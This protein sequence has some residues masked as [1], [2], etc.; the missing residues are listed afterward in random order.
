MIRVLIADDHI[1]LVE[2]LQLMLHQ[3]KNIEVVGFAA[4]GSE[5][6]DQCKQLLLDVVL[7][8][9]KM[10][11]CDGLKA[12]GIIKETC[13]KTKVIIL[14]TFEDRKKIIESLTRGVDGYLLKDIR[15]EALIQAITCVHQGLCVLQGSVS[16]I[17]REELCIHYNYKENRFSNLNQLKLDDIEIIRLISNGKN[18]KEIAE[19]MNFT[20]GTIKN[21]V[22]KIL[23]ITGVKDRT[24]LV[25]YALKNDLI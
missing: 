23:E 24:Q 20:E 5:A 1:L 7:M 2:S 17:L 14:T 16:D 13:P 3:N 19:I 10:L 21:K 15:P 25:V 22:S 9:I 18:N 4:N 8:D 12:A 11:E 6:V